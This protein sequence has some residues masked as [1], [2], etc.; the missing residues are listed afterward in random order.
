MPQRRGLRSPGAKRNRY[1]SVL[2]R[3]PRSCFA[4]SMWSCLSV[5]LSRFGEMPRRWVRLA[6]SAAAAGA[7]LRER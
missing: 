7:S 6:D 4:L 5:L 2:T 1:A 3:A